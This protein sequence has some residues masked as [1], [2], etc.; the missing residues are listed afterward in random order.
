MQTAP[1]ARPESGCW[2]VHAGAFAGPAGGEEFPAGG[3]DPGVRSMG[4]NRRGGLLGSADRRGMG[5]LGRRAESEPGGAPAQAAHKCP[6]GVRQEGPNLYQQVSHTSAQSPPGKTRS[7][8]TRDRET[9]RPCIGRTPG[10]SETSGPAAPPAP[11]GATAPTSLPP[12][13]PNGTRVFPTGVPCPGNRGTPPMCCGTSA[14]QAAESRTTG[15]GG[16]PAAR[17]P[18]RAKSPA[19]RAGRRAWE[20]RR[21]PPTPPPRNRGRGPARQAGDDDDG[22]C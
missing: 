20:G 8:A 5:S 16:Q 7:P 19:K 17:P 3:E 22:H 2:N 13:E 9:G 14:R 12:R 6:R 11:Q 18:G 21:G 15:R 1:G 4:V 10:V